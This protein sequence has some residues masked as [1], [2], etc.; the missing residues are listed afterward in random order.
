M[1]F[2]NHKRA[3]SRAF[4]I[5]SGYLDYADCNP[6]TGRYPPFR[7]A[8][9]RPQSAYY[10][11]QENMASHESFVTL[12]PPGPVYAGGFPAQHYPPPHGRAPLVYPS[13]FNAEL[14]AYARQQYQQYGNAPQ[15]MHKTAPNFISNN[16]FAPPQMSHRAAPPVMPFQH[17]PAP[18]PYC[19][20]ANDPIGPYMAPEPACE[21]VR[22][23]IPMHP[24]MHPDM[25]SMQPGAPPRRMVDEIPPPRMGRLTRSPSHL[26]FQDLTLRDAHHTQLPRACTPPRAPMLNRTA[27]GAVPT[28]MLRE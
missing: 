13:Q 2:H 28:A 8:A 3:H 7:P 1:S 18:Y 6:H 10:L 12:N 22:R 21:T 14:A 24:S 17:P 19:F 15:T 9:P 5:D 27:M 20:P 4:S 25:A 16:H 26:K 23:N 11:D